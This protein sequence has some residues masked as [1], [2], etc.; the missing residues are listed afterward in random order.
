[1]FWSD[2]L[3]H[4]TDWSFQTSEPGPWSKGKF[5]RTLCKVRLN[6]TTTD[7][8][9]KKQLVSLV[10]RKAMPMHV[11]ELKLVERSIPPSEF[12]AANPHTMIPSETGYTLTTSWC[13]GDL[14][15]EERIYHSISRTVG[16]GVHQLFDGSVITKHHTLES[17]RTHEPPVDLNGTIR[18]YENEEWKKNFPV[19]SKVS[20]CLFRFSYE[21][22]GQ[23]LQRLDVPGLR[24]EVY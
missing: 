20:F 18:R 15:T 8:L 2:P 23:F 11:D 1:M 24:G 9:K 4:P 13:L 3:R 21:K 5:G 7:R 19:K 6:L 12:V 10:R 14:D 22:D 17:P 16:T